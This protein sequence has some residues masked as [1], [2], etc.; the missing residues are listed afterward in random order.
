ME[1]MRDNGQH[2]AEGD[3][4]VFASLGSDDVLPKR[5]ELNVLYYDATVEC[6][7]TVSI[8]WGNALV[9][10]LAGS[11]ACGRT[12]CE[13]SA[14]VP[15]TRQDGT[16]NPCVLEVRQLLVVHKD[17]VDEW[18]GSAAK[19]AV[20]ILNEADAVCGQGL[21][22]DFNEDES[23]GARK[24]PTLLRVTASKRSYPF[25]VYARQIA[26]PLVFVWDSGGLEFATFYK[27]GQ[28]G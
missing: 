14:Y 26:C 25:A 17:G 21:E 19:L 7:D 6:A 23:V 9:R 27:M 11:S 1:Q 5:S 22:S 10:T 28:H 8:G 2:Q 13:F 12:K 15:F 20:G 3:L 16:H 24:C 4:N 18:P